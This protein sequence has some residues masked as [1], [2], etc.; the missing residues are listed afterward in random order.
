MV[1]VVHASHRRRDGREDALCLLVELLPGGGQ[2]HA[3]GGPHQQSAY[4]LLLEGPDLTAEHRLGDVELFRRPAEVPVLGHRDEVPELAQIE[5]HAVKVSIAGKGI[6][7]HRWH[8]P[9]L[10]T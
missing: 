8:A 7:R 4:Q 5:I 9:K 10:K 6:G 3:A 2:L 1:D